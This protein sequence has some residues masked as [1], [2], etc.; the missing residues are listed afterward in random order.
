LTNGGLSWSRR[1]PCSFRSPRLNRT[2]DTRAA[3]RAVSGHQ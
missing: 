2:S 1:F 3:R